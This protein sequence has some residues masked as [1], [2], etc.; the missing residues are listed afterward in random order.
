VFE[1]LTHPKIPDFKQCVTFGKLRT[2]QSK[3]IYNSYHFV[4]CYGLPLL[5]M[6]FCYVKIF[7][8]IA[9]HTKSSSICRGSGNELHRADSSNSALGLGLFAG[10]KKL[11]KAASF[12]ETLPA[13]LPP[14]PQPPLSPSSA[15]AATGNSKKTSLNSQSSFLK[16]IRNKQKKC[17]KI[18]KESLSRGKIFINRFLLLLLLL[19]LK[20][21]KNEQL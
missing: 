6:I 17:S 15:K 12:S 10:E 5:I 9:L 21:T 14:A 4:G 1:V 16:K 19:L 20:F 18:G 2:L 13:L 3:L 8:T 7:T 11:S